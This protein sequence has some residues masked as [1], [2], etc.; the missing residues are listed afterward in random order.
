MPYASSLA[1]LANDKSRSALLTQA[2]R[3]ANQLRDLL[4]NGI[5]LG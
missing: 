5:G 3:R 2:P 4:D 1:Q